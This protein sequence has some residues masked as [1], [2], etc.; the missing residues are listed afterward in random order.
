MRGPARIAALAFC[1]ACSLLA[2]EVIA[3][4]SRAAPG[5]DDKGKPAQKGFLGVGL[6]ARTLPGTKPPRACVAVTTV[7]LI[8]NR[9]L[10]D[11]VPAEYQ[12]EILEHFEKL[13]SIDVSNEEPMAHPFPVFNVLGAD[14][15]SPTL[16]PEQALVNAPKQRDQQLVVP[17]VVDDA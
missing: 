17:K 10:P 13:K 5:A 9:S 3:D 14:E 6:R 7:V 16:S 2:V 15:A 8:N 1:V 4:E 11:Y 12:L